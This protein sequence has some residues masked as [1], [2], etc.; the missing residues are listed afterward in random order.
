MSTHEG[1]LFLLAILI[2][3]FLKGE[4]LNKYTYK[5]PSNKSLLS[6]EA[7]CKIDTPFIPVISSQKCHWKISISNKMAHLLMS[8]CSVFFGLASVGPQKCSWV[9]YTLKHGVAH[10]PML[11]SGHSD[12]ILVAL[13]IAEHARH[14]F[15]SPPK[16]SV[17]CV[18]CEVCLV[19]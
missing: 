9:W 3:L 8:V 4:K 2:F 17:C 7:F 1:Q 5:G 19:G 12:F 6:H 13:F 14:Q 18:L 15:S 10:N 16:A 11:H